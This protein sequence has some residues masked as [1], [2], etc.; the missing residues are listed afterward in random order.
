[1]NAQSLAAHAAYYA[2]D[3]IRG[4]ILH[5]AHRNERRTGDALPALLL[6][7]LVLEDP[8]ASKWTLAD[9]V[10]QVNV[11]VRR[12]QLCTLTQGAVTYLATP[13]SAGVAWIVFE[14]LAHGS[15]SDLWH[16]AREVNVSARDLVRVAL[17]PGRFKECLAEECVNRAFSPSWTW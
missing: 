6:A 16:A 9:V 5:V 11:L 1:M 10:E 4:T 2:T 3:L 14:R 8:R 7:R 12:G 13:C 15:W 17:R